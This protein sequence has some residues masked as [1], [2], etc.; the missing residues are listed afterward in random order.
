MT[1]LFKVSAYPKKRG[2]GKIKNKGGGG[3]IKCQYKEIVTLERHD[4]LTFEN[5]WTCALATDIVSVQGLGFR[6]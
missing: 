3:E 5:L 2:R 4:L 1:V 6:V